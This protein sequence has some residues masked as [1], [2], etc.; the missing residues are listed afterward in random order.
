M[1]EDSGVRLF[2]GAAQVEAVCARAWM[3]TR[4]ACWEVSGSVGTAVEGRARPHQGRKCSELCFVL[5]LLWGSFLQHCCAFWYFRAPT[6]RQHPEWPSWH[7][8]PPETNLNSLKSPFALEPLVYILI[9]QTWV[10]LFSVPLGDGAPCKC[11]PT[12]GE[13]NNAAGFS[14]V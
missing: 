7:R 5:Q 6:V 4:R 3:H 10:S 1:Q 8:L 14:H 11:A 9:L 12:V 2:S 13:R